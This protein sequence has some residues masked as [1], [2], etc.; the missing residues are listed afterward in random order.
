[1]HT[2]IKKWG[3]SASV[4]I[5]QSL[6]QAAHL[7]LDQDVE[8]LEED[9]MLVILPVRAVAPDLQALLDQITDAN[10]HAEIPTGAARGHEVW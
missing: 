5:P 7:T 8:V 9:G 1:M 3:N 4:R 10:Q 2:T 6:M